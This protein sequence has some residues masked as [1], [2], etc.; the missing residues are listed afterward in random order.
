MT[1]IDIISQDT[2]DERI[3]KALRNKVNIANAIMGEEYKEW[4]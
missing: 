4:I 2:I 1:Y 3:V